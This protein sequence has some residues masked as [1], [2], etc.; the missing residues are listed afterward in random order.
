[1]ATAATHQLISSRWLAMA[2]ILDLSYQEPKQKTNEKILKIG[3]KILK[4]KNMQN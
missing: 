1:M 4:L 2:A 3:E